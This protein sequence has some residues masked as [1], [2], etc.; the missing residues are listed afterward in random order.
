MHE[1]L[2]ICMVY[3]FKEFVADVKLV[4]DID[5]IFIFQTGIEVNND[6]LFGSKLK[7]DIDRGKLKRNCCEQ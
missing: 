5:S 4:P 7:F 1:T 3:A 6:R 2:H